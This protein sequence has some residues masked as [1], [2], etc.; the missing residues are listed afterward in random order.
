MTQPLIVIFG[1][2]TI[3]CYLGGVLISRS[4]KVILVG[5]KKIADTITRYGLRTSN[6]K[7]AQCRI[8]PYK[9]HFSTD[10]DVVRAADI[11]FVSVK[12]GDTLTVARELSQTMP[13]HA[14]LVSLQNG[15]RNT[16]SFREELPNTHVLAGT[17]SFNVI[18]NGKGNFHQGTGG[19]LVIEAS[20]YAKKIKQLFVNSGIQ[21]DIHRN[22]TAVQWTKLLMNLN[23][24]I[25]ALAGIPLH[26][27][28]NDPGYRRVMSHVIQEALYIFRHAGIATCR[29][30]KVIPSAL[31]S[32]LRLPTWA[33]RHVAHAMLNIDPRARSSM[34]DDL[35]NGRK[36]EIDFL[37]GEIARLA[38]TLGLSAPVNSNIIRLIKLAELTGKGSPHLPAMSLLP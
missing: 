6:W 34:Y 28:L 30:G 35:Q 16:Q 24:A 8:A 10:P 4:H 20:E 23:N 14:I 17:V 25:N 7:E 12:S 26:Q 36:T 21:V 9:I 38:S 2:G 33:F 11:V 29:I 27:Q 19:S 5:R 18:N 32:I 1:A 3:G 31:P 13:T 37:N 22:I 15:V